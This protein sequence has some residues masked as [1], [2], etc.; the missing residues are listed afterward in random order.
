[1][2]HKIF[3]WKT[4]TNCGDKKPRGLRPTNLNP[5]FEIKSH[6]FMWSLY[7]KD[8]LFSAYNLIHVCDAATTRCS[9]VD[10]SIPPKG[11]R[12]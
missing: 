9:L 8:L 7:P 4:P 2:R 12:Y 6:R 10:H 3:T 5:L 1:M 11:I